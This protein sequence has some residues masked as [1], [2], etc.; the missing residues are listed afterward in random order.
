[1]ALDIIIKT[2]MRFDDA[3]KAYVERRTTEERTYRESKRCL[4]RYLA[5]SIYR[6]LEKT[7]AALPHVNMLAKTYRVSHLKCSPNSSSPARVCSLALVVSWPCIW[8][9]RLIG[10][11]FN[12]RRTGLAWIQVVIMPQEGQ[13]VSVA[14]GSIGTRLLPD[15][16]VAV[17]TR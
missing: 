3:T 7:M 5:W 8:L 12:S 14:T 2:R 6:Q 9:I 1:M 10:V 4:K 11:G 13:A 15:S 16:W 17:M